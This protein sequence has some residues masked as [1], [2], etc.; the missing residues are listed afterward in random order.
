MLV[1]NLIAVPA[2]AG[3]VRERVNTEYLPSG[4][5]SAI[6]RQM[7]DQVLAEGRLNT[8]HIMEILDRYPNQQFARTLPMRAVAE[9]RDAVDSYIESLELYSELERMKVIVAAAHLDLSR[10]DV[11]VEEVKTNLATGIVM[12]NNR[13]GLR[14]I[15][16]FA[17]EAKNMLLLAASSQRPG[18]SVG[19][20]RTLDDYWWFDPGC[21]TI[22]AGRPGSGKTSLITSSIFEGA[23]PEHPEAFFSIE[24]PAY[25]IAQRLA[26]GEVGIPLHDLNR[27]K[28]TA[29]QLSVVMN[30]LDKLSDRGIYIDEEVVTMDDILYRAMAMPHTPRVIWIDYGEKVDVARDGRGRRDLELGYVYT[31]AKAIAKRLKCH[32]VVLAQLGRGVEE[33]EDKWPSMSD[34]SQSGAAEKDGDYVI[35]LMR[36]EYYISRGLRCRVLSEGD[37]QGTCYCIVAKSRNGAVDTVRLAYNSRTMRFSEYI[38]NV[39][40]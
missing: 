1:R 21:I 2:I 3:Y 9:E 8:G 10:G 30:E 27:G 33:T 34:I 4:D 29:S 20:G 18:R 31:R 13:R 5:S 17:G 19:F 6:L 32:V 28:T 35:L 37:R 12:P 36:P 14:D 11:D 25:S 23:S 26:A 22:L 38:L 7:L 15:G 16:R 24:M 39:E 40:D